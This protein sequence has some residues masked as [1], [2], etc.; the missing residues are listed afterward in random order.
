MKIPPQ[1]LKGITLKLTLK[2]SSFSKGEIQWG[3]NR[4]TFLKE[5]YG[6]RGLLAYQKQLLNRIQLLEKKYS[7]SFTGYSTDLHFDPK[8]FK[9][10]MLNMLFCKSSRRRFESHISKMEKLLRKK[11]H[12]KLNNLII[13]LLDFNKKKRTE[14]YFSHCEYF[15]YQKGQ[16]KTPKGHN[17]NVIFLRS[18]YFYQL[19]HAIRQYAYYKSRADYYIRKIRKLHP[20]LTFNI[21]YNRSVISKLPKLINVLKKTPRKVLDGKTINIENYAGTSGWNKTKTIINM[22]IHSIGSL[23]KLLGQ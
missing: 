16:H 9:E 18:S 22:G 19:R 3:C 14:L 5:I 4:I 8:T 13:V 23:K 10:L 6:H 17:R 12:W 15:V 11:K 20:R 21:Q 2:K 1:K 7:I